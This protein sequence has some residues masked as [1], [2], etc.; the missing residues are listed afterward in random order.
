MGPRSSRVI[1][2]LRETIQHA[3]GTPELGPHDP[4]VVELRRLLTQ[5]IAEREAADAR[6]AVPHD[7]SDDLKAQSNPL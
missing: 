6:A 4:G 7:S 2:I 5:W 1:Q 3:E